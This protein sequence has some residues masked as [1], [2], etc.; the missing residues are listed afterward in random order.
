MAMLAERRECAT[1]RRKGADADEANGTW[2]QIPAEMVDFPRQTVKGENSEDEGMG[3]LKDLEYQSLTRE[4][5][6][7]DTGDCGAF[8]TIKKTVTW[9]S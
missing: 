8:I 4:V 3:G 2:I 5:A 7:P 9:Q 1:G 6:H